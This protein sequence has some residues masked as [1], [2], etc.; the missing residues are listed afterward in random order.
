MGFNGWPT[1]DMLQLKYL[2][3]PEMLNNCRSG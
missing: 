2:K 1:K 3:Q